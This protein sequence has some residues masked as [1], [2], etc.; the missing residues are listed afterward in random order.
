MRL[1]VSEVLRDKKRMIDG[2]SQ[3][4]G[5]ST[6]LLVQDFKRDFYLTADEAYEYGMIDR[7]LVPKKGDVMLGKA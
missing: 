5:R 1:E 7:V 6:D 3:F 2:L 4:T